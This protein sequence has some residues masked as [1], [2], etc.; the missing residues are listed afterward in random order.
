[1]TFWAT[2]KELCFYKDL[3]P[4]EPVPEPTEKIHVREIPREGDTN[5][6]RWE[7]MVDGVC[8]CRLNAFFREGIPTLGAHTE[9][10]FRGY[11]FAQL[12]YRYVTAILAREGVARAWAFCHPANDASRA[13]L[14]KVG[15][16]FDRSVYRFAIGPLR[17]GAWLDGI[18]RRFRQ[19]T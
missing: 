5:P 14:E 13:V 9:K 7:V 6:R 1:M 11:G 19:R 10:E 4:E 15:F 2:G 8:V 12:G 16:R 17:F 3:D 18:R